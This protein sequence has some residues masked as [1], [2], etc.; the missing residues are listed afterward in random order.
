MCPAPNIYKRRQDMKLIQTMTA[1]ALGLALI[2]PALAAVSPEE[3][4]KLD[5][6]LTPFGAQRAASA[7]GVIPAWDGGLT[8]PPSQ[9][10]RR[11]QAPQPVAG[12]AA[13]PGNH[14]GQ[15]G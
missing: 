10:R 8:E 2:N 11:R 1:T 15:Y 12:R 6:E 3:A 4:A 13:L 14:P 5:S 9:L 7:D